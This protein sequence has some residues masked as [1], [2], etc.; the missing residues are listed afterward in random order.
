MTTGIAY[1]LM[2]FLTLD[3]RMPPSPSWH[4]TRAECEEHAAVRVA[5]LEWTG[6]PVAWVAC[7]RVRVGR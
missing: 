4:A 7:Q 5:H 2:V 3:T 1:A 6:Q